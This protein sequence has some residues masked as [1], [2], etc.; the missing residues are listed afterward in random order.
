MFGADSDRHTEGSPVEL[1]E[2]EAGA[3]GLDA[4]HSLIAVRCG[5]RERLQRALAYL[6]GLPLP[7]ERTNGWR[8]AV[9]AGDG[10]MNRR[11]YGKTR[12]KGA[13]AVPS[14]GQ[15]CLVVQMLGQ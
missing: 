15:L 3:C 14:G 1:E 6:T 13:R 4:V 11:R 8:W 5:R 7:L 2:V 9:L 10:T 12:A